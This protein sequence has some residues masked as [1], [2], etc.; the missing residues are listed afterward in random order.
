ME[1]GTA[2]GSPP[3]THSLA[4]ISSAPISDADFHESVSAY[5]RR[6]D[7]SAWND[8]YIVGDVHGCID[9]LEQLVSVIELTPDDLLIFVGDLVRKGP[10][11]KAVLE[12]VRGHDNMLSIRGNNEDKL[13]HGRKSLDS[14][15]SDDIA[16]LESLPIVISW[17]DAMAVHGGIDPTMNLENQPVEKVL[18]CRSVPPENGYDGP[19]WFERYAGPIQT[20][21]GHTV[22]SDPIKASYA[23]GLDT[24][25]VYGNKLTAYDWNADSFTSVAARKT[26]VNRDDSK[27]L[28]TD[29]LTMLKDETESPDGNELTVSISQPS[30]PTVGSGV[31]LLSD[32]ADSGPPRVSYGPRNLSAVPDV[33]DPD[34]SHSDWYLNRELSELSFQK[35][36]LHEALDPRNPIL[37]R[38]RFL[39]LFSKNIDEFCMKRIGGLKQQIASEVSEYTPDGYTPQEQWS[40]AHSTLDD[41][42]SLHDTACDEIINERLPEVDIE[43]VDY[44]ELSQRERAALRSHFESEILPTLT[45]LT[46]DPAHPFPFISNLSLSLAVRT[47]GEGSDS[48]FSRVKIPENQ[49]RLLEIDTVVANND[50]STQQKAITDTDIDRFILLE[51]VIAGNLD[52]LFPNVEILDWSTFRVTRNAEVRRNEEVAEGL[53]EMIEDVLRDRRFATVVRLEVSSD[54]PQ[55]TRDL[56]KEQLEVEQK[57]VFVR[58]PPLN[59]RDFSR[60]AGLERP[61]HQLPDW[62]PKPHPRF[63]DIDTTES[64]DDIFS[65]IRNKDILVHHPY[66]SFEKTVQRLLKTAA[67]DDDVLA[68]KAAIYRTSR[69]SEVIESL[70]E[71]ARNG[72]QVAVMVELKAR[73]DEKN[74][75][76]W[77][78]RLEEEGIHV[79]YGTIGLK[80]HTKTALIVRQEDDGVQLY[81]H[82][83]TGNYHAETAKGYV[84]LGLM[85]NDPDI[86]YDLTRLFNFFTGHCSHEEY[87]KLLVA[88]STLRTS[89][90]DR[91]RAEAEHARDGGDG[92]IVA[93]MNALEDPDVAQELYKAASVGVEIDLIVRDICRIRPGVEG[94]TETV[95][96]R[97]IVG[98]FLEHSRI[99]YFEND[100]DP[101]Y[102]IGSADWM[103]RNL[104]RRVE[105]VTPIEDPDIQAELERLLSY[106]LQDNRKAWE[107]RSDGS[108]VQQTPE[109]DD[110][111]FNVQS[112]LQRRTQ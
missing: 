102:Y 80:T 26:Y 66:H 85:T 18:T 14:L 37:E 35:R 22:L 15:D 31:G 62:T 21:F 82:V 47:R 45:P 40:L 103:T 55:E 2:T 104:D 6:V 11:S 39:G 51:Q 7:V 27:I 29:Q 48:K 83:G 112:V 54:M 96:V 5:H 52:L 16:Y 79:A 36:V 57:E 13:I 110:T 76:R 63:N 86:G 24:G 58:S 23:I 10:N 30:S 32:P 81:S 1:P 3:S 70:I 92:R 44:N 50:V 61:D 107:M 28:T 99:F 75:L 72:K 108:Y 53:I 59:L 20:F 12:Y 9:E 43:V 74:N 4:D 65:V 87:R 94:V 98:R 17:A 67:R 25:C 33:D 8:I 105:A 38:V 97:S 91:I 78:E 93:K 71:A 88:P 77:V 111:V 60:I 64:N 46:F 100:G 90:V 84:D 109:S 68:I 19:F 95:R 101:L 56:L 49:P 41:M 42:F 106:Y 89:L 34:F 69:D 73:F